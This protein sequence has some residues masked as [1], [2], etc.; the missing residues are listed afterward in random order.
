MLITQTLDVAAPAAT[1]WQVVTDLDRYPQWNP[2]VVACR[3]TLEPGTPIAMRVRVLP[4][5]AQ[6]QRE[7]IFEHVPGRC[8]RYGIH[9]LPLGALASE[10]SHVVESAGEEHSRYVSR[11]EL[12]GWLAPVVATLLGGRLERGFA[13]MSAG[14]KARAEALRSAALR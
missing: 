8:L 13:A 6:P 7:T 12:R 2:F 11:F 1:V 4:F 3:S 9:P 5:L 10:R 14:I